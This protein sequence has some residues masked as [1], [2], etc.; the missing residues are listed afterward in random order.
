MPPFNQSTNLKALRSKLVLFVF[1]SFIV[2]FAQSDQKDSR[3]YESLARKAYQEKNYASFLANMQIAADMRVN[4]PRLMYNLA[5]AYALNNKPNE[6]LALLK[7]QADMGLVF[8]IAT[9]HDFDS[10]RTQP[11]FTAIL[12]EVE[13]NQSQT[14]SSVPAFTVHE[15]GLVPEGIAY[16]EEGGE[17]YLSSVYKREILK[18]TKTGDAHVFSSEADGLWSVM[19]LKVD[20]ARRLLW[21]CTV[22]HPQMRNFIAQDKGKTALVKFD[23]QTG[24]LLA[25]F[26]PGD[27]TKPHWFGDLAINS[28]GDVYTTDSITPAV[29]VVRHTKNELETLLDGEPFVS[30]QGLDFT[31]DQN[32]LFVADYAKGVFLVDLITKEVKSIGADFTLLGIDGLYYYKGTLIGVQNGVNPNRVIKLSLNRD[33]TRF[34]HFETIEAN[35]PAFDEP[36]LGVLVKDRFYLVANSQ[37]GSI[38]DTGHLAAEDKLKYPIILKIK[39]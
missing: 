22:A 35:N 14:I 24:K 31:T 33:R 39:L 12:K 34:D 18:I 26:S 17:F 2:S 38:D 10:L 11:E 20:S 30:P 19:G 7:R 16:D 15:K 27:T 25:R 21:V 32:K 8:S 28:A 4:H 23:L 3:Y 37:W 13:H 6:A 29:Y 5:A 9:N 36:T 1:T